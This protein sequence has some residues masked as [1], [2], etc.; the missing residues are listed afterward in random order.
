[1]AASS[2]R[3]STSRPV[4]RALGL[5]GEGSG[6]G[7]GDGDDDDDD[8]DD[9]GVDCFPLL[10]AILDAVDV[11]VPTIAESVLSLSLS[12]SDG[13]AKH[14]AESALWASAI[15]TLCSAKPVTMMLTCVHF[16][17]SLLIFSSSQLLSIP[18]THC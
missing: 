17:C 9:E 10:F 6:S 11:V 2:A 7:G 13:K 16:C 14:R 15:H 3:M 4:I 12:L 18:L 1:M 8:E 5:N